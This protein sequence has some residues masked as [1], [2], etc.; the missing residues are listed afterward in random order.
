MDQEMDSLN[1]GLK[2]KNTGEE[3]QEIL[4]KPP[5]YAYDAWQAILDKFVSK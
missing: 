2:G 4:D 1:A 5:A 3:L